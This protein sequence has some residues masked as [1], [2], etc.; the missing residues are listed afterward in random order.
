MLL[1]GT[2]AFGVGAAAKVVVWGGSSIKHLLEPDSDFPTVKISVLPPFP[3]PFLT[4]FVEPVSYP[5]TSITSVPSFKSTI[6]FE[7][8]LLASVGSGT[9]EDGRGTANVASPG[10]TAHMDIALSPVGESEAMD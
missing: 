5:A 1:A 7:H 8:S 2:P 10:M 3:L 4:P 6:Q 9:S